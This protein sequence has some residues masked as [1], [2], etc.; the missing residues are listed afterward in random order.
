MYRGQSV[1][2]LIATVRSR[3]PFVQPAWNF[4]LQVGGRVIN[5]GRGGTESEAK[6]HF[7]IDKEF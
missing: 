7:R 2:R 4:I 6:H 3:L 1:I 5:A